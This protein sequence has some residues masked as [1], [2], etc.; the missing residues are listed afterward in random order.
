MNRLLLLLLLSFASLESS[1]TQWIQRADVPAE[2]RHRPCGIGFQNRGYMGLGHYNGTGVETYFNDWWSFDPGTNSW[3]QKANYPGNNGIGDLGTHCWTYSNYIYVGLGE[4][5]HRQLFR[6]NPTSNTW[7]QMTS[8]PSGINFQDTQEMVVDDGA[9]FMNLYNGDLYYYDNASDNWSMVGTTGMPMGYTYSAFTYN[10]NIFIKADYEMYMFETATGIWYQ[11]ISAGSF[12]GFAIRGSAE[13][14]LDGY[15]YVV[16]GHGPTTSEITSEVWKFD[17]T[18]YQWTQLEDFPGSSRR[19]L[20]SFVIGNKA[21]IYCGTNGT[22]FKDL[23]E[24]APTLS[25]DE[26]AVEINV[27][28]YPNPATDVVNI[29]SEKLDIFEVKILDSKGLLVNQKTTNSGELSIDIT[30]LPKGTYYWQVLD[31][32]VILKSEKIIV[33]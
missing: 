19:Y 13:F 9:Y 10:D 6:F 12:P 32:S 15:F 14:F 23:W 26:P 8:A 29:R 4:V 25:T 21:Y 16:C 3:T 18:T 27:S 5:Q 30:T 17:P 7:E 28:I 20:K 1:A 2:G 22:N 24:F 11:V 31:R 33:Q